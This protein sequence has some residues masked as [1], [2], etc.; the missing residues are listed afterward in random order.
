MDLENELRLAE[1]IIE[2]A[3]S[4][5]W[6]NTDDLYAIID[7]NYFLSATKQGVH[8]IEWNKIL[9]RLRNG[10]YDEIYKDK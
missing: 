3:R 1:K 5:T 10:Y 2:Q 9:N 7:L 4:K 8:S 6:K